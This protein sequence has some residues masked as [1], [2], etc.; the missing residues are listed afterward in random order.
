MTPPE[1]NSP[2]VICSNTALIVNPAL[3]PHTGST[4]SLSQSGLPSS[5]NS[6]SQQLN[7]GINVP[8]S[9]PYRDGPAIQQTGLPQ[10][11]TTSDPQH[12]QGTIV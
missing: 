8:P 7:L 3:A 2:P 10:L 5:S 9:S 1:E 4:L 11:S 12:L 6:L